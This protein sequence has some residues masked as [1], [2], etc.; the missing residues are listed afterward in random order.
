MTRNKKDIVIKRKRIARLGHVMGVVMARAGSKGL[1]GK[2][3]RNLLG[4]PVIAYT[5]E[6]LKQA[7]NISNRIVSSDDPA[8]LAFARSE[9]IYQI[10]RPPELASDTASTDAVL[11]HA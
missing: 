6:H 10:E 1:P 7:K 9:D 8:V 2:A 11:R 4:K 5:F 3:M